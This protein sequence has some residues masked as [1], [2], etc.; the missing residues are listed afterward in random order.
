MNNIFAKVKSLRLKPY[1]KLISDQSLF[2][3]I[4]INLN[5]CIAY[6]P[7]HNLDEDSWFKIEK[8]SAQK[9]CLDFLKNSFD[10]KDYNDLIKNQFSKISF[11]F[12]KQEEN[13]YFQKVTPGLFVHRKTLK[14]GEVAEIENSDARLIINQLPDAVYFKESDTLIFK[15]LPSITSIFVGIDELYKEATNEE[16]AEF[17][18]QPF[19]ELVDGYNAE[20]VSK[21]NRKRIGL[22]IATLGKMTAAQKLEMHIYIES[23][24]ETKLLFNGETNRFNISTD[25]ELKMLLYGIEQRYYTTPFGHEKRLANSVVPII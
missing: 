12:S 18:N 6:N 2:D 15:S 14:F 4:V 20:K 5:N 24:C 23:Y 19:I 21:P 22:A 13:F 17:I 16:V 25:D 9:Y 7:D 3:N 10:S 8:F 1:F 11:I